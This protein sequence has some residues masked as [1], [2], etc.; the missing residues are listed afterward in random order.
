MIINRGEHLTACGLK[1]IINLRATLNRGLTPS[2]IEAFPNTVAA[3]RPQVDNINVQ[4][5]DPQ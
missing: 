3:P 4:S 5:I 1:A 2:L